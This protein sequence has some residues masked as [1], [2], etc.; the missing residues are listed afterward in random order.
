MSETSYRGAPIERAAR[1]AYEVY[2]AGITGTAWDDT[3]DSMRQIWR[4]TVSTA[5]NSYKIYGGEITPP[6]E[7][8]RTPD[9]TLYGEKVY[10]VKHPLK[11]T[12][13]LDAVQRPVAVFLNNVDVGEVCTNIEMAADSAGPTRVTLDLLPDSVETVPMAQDPRSKLPMTY[14]RT[15]T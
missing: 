3:T 6:S 15:D 9:A 5:I 11:I 13:G 14:T 10:T 7:P 1:T 4:D 8:P 2:S 12:L